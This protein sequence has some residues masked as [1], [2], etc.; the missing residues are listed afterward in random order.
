LNAQHYAHFMAVSFNYVDGE[1]RSWTLPA[2]S[3]E[4]Y[5]VVKTDQGFVRI[6][7][8]MEIERQAINFLAELGFTVAPTEKNIPQNLV[9][10]SEGRTIVDSAS[11]WRDFIQNTIP[12]LKR[13]GWLIEIADGFKLNFQTA[14]NWNAEITENQNDWFEMHFNVE[15]DSQS[16]PLLPLIMPVL[17]SYDPENLPDVLNIALGNHQYLSIP[18]D[19]IKPI[20]AVLLELF[21]TSILEKDGT[22]KISRFNAASLADMEEQNCGLFSLSGGKELRELGQKLKNFTGIQDVELPDNLQ[23]ELRHYQQQGLNWLQFLRD[24]KFAGILADDMGLGK[25]IQTL[26]HL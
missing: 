9:L 4:D 22:L 10:F 13:E 17:E 14:Q 25:T 24:Y 3:S 16:Y 19:K 12:E 8:A 1:A 7:R 6:K 26:A 23:A 2:G 21:N 5:S 18:S 20:L 15:V 11:R